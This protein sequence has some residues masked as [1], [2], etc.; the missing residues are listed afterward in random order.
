M[1]QDPMVSP[2]A[3]A[4]VPLGTLLP[5]Q[6]QTGAPGPAPGAGAGGPVPPMAAHPRVPAAGYAPW[7]Q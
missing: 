2:P 5:L 3:P 6:G 4:M 7:E 1:S